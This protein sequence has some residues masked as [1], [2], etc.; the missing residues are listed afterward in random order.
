MRKLFFD[1][2]IT[3]HHS[4]YIG[5]L[6]N[7]LFINNNLND[8]FFFVVHPEFSVRFPDIGFKAK[9][10]KNISWI[11]ITMEEFK[12]TQSGDIVRNSFST[13]KIMDFYARKYGIDHV[14]LLY[15]NTFQLPCTF[16]RTNY[17]ISGILFLQFYRMDKN[18]IIDKL[19]YYR[20]YL[21]TKFYTL[22]SRLETVFILNDQ[23]TVDYFN[24]E[25]KTLQFKM[26]P[27]P[28][29]V[30]NPIPDFDIYEH[31]NIERN[32][33]IFLHIGSLGDRKGTFEI[34]E[35]AKFIT[36][37]LQNE[38]AIL[39]VGKASEHDAAIMSKK[40]EEVTKES[41]A[42]VIWDKRFVSSQMMKSLFDLCDAVLI[43]YKNAEASSG[44]LGH[45]AMANKAVIAPKSGLLKEII[46]RYNLGILI[47]KVNSNLIAEAI[48]FLAESN[49]SYNGSKDFIKIHNT[50]I[51]AK[52]LVYQNFSVFED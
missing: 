28:I 34:I 52:K 6:I 48:A 17:L 18:K 47:D 15:F 36:N 27:D 9:Q 21:I 45:A 49:Y 3:G 7:Y 2:Q 19:K 24:K 25:F 20:K 13:H 38:I 37:D 22:N 14:V 39:L 16:Y 10:V 43:P 32:R 51:F 44:I 30:L 46:E 12:K 11:E 26:L 1:I 42:I 8:E 5:H 23:K 41:K 29:P 31:Y 35:S 40:I 33:K 50:N 4:E